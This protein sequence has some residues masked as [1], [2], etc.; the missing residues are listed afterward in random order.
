VSGLATL[1]AQWKILIDQN[2]WTPR[3]KRER[4]DQRARQKAIR[5]IEAEVWLIYIDE[6]INPDRDPL[7]LDDGR[8]VDFD[9][10][11]DESGEGTGYKMRVFTDF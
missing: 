1:V 7:P 6:Q 5:Q 9:P 10:V 4:D 8:V 3:N 11:M 2:N